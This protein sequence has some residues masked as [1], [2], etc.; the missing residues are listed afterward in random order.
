M[1][2][3]TRDLINEHEAILHVFEILDRALADSTRKDEEMLKFG[4]ELVQFLKTFADQCHHGKEEDH[5]FK[6]LVERGV[7]NQ[8][9]PVGAMLYE[10]RLGREHIASMSASLQAGDLAGF[11]AS[12]VLY[13]DLLRSHIAKENN[14]LFAIAD[15]VLDDAVQADLFEKFEVHEETVIGQGVHEKLHAMIDD[16]EKQFAA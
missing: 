15:Q 3:A 11:K 6:A 1:G 12:A 9:G 4:T 7:P 8:G 14:I 13:R 16:W 5:L 10:H 2:K